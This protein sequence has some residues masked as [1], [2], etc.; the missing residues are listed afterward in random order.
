MR[1]RIGVF[2]AFERGALNTILY[3]NQIRDM[4]EYLTYI[5]VLE[6]VRRMLVIV[7]LQLT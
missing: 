4:Y 5:N 2:R 6:K 1:S 3:V 7:L